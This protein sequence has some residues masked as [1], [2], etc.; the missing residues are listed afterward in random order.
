[1]ALLDIGNIIIINR[2]DHVLNGEQE[3]PII[4]MHILNSLLQFS[5]A[6]YLDFYEGR[7]AVACVCALCHLCST[8]PAYLGEQLSSSTWIY[9]L[10]LWQNLDNPGSTIAGSEFPNLMVS[11]VRVVTLMDTNCWEG[12]PSIQLTVTALFLCC[13]CDPNQLEL[14]DEPPKGDSQVVCQWAFVNQISPET[15]IVTTGF[16]AQVAPLPPSQCKLLVIFGSAH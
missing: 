1:M 9:V 8:C 10:S 7:I 13:Q 15:V 16:P 4:T 6:K 11:H 12:D 5:F 2:F 3:L 14:G